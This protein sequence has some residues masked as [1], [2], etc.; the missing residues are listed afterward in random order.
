MWQVPICRKELVKKAAT[1]AKQAFKQWR[2]SP[3][4]TRRQILYNLAEL[5]EQER[6]SL[7]E[8][9]AIEIGKPVIYGDGEVTRG[10]ELLK[11]VAAFDQK[12][13]TVPQFSQGTYRHCPIGAVAIITPWNN[14]LAI[15]IGKIAPA[16]LYG[17]TL[18][19]K[20]ALPGTAI[21][22]KI[23]DL[24]SKAG[25]PPGVVN[26]VSGDRLTAQALMSD[27]NV[28]AV[29]LSGSS[30]A[31]YFAQDICDRRRIPLQAE[32]GGNN[33]AIIWS[34]CDLENAAKQVI[35]GAF[36]F[37]G[38][39]CTANRRVI[40]DIHCYDEFITQLKQAMTEL[41]WGDPLSLETH[42]GPLISFQKRDQVA[43]MLTRIKTE[44]EM[45]FEAYLD[46]IKFNKI[47]KGAYSCPTVICCDRP[48]H[49][50]VQTETFAPVLVVQKAES[51]E[52][53]I[54]LCNG[55]T[56]G[57]VAALFSHSLLRQEQFLNEIQAGVLKLNSATTDV[58]V[59]IPFG[60]WKASGVGCP[61]HGSSN[62]EFYTRTQ[63]IYDANQK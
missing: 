44:V 54:Q 49:E 24:L 21:A 17:N 33:A 48:N 1:A 36:G 37:A 25:C 38:Q 43:A 29:T 57:L 63:A 55:V 16:L 34:D 40:V 32:L 47:P 46:K 39:R 6:K 22:I 11:S 35:H 31:G 23:M 19:W 42:I 53:A 60:G 7:V 15:P 61:E 27:Q 8:Q 12:E 3:I 14:P 59:N 18:I 51:W 10:I 50:I 62:R 4:Y 2:N 58:A 26:F 52:Q 45:I 56:Q 30:T 13:I 20:P 5:L 9:L 28:D 41:V